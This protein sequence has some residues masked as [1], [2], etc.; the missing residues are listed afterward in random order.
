MKKSIGIAAIFAI[1]SS[2]FFT[3]AVLAVEITGLYSST[4]GQ[5]SL[6]QDPDNRYY[7]MGEYGD[8][9]GTIYALRTDVDSISG[10][11]MEN[12]SDMRCETER[13]G[14][15]YW[16]R[17]SFVWNTDGLPP[18]SFSGRWT[19]CDSYADGVRWTGIRLAS[20]G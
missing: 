9:G 20:K 6:W 11:W 14:T 16:G 18:G 4:E 19:Y 12:N 3:N 8:D 17:V 1:V 15:Y 5:V 13:D 10:Y 2:A 7:Y